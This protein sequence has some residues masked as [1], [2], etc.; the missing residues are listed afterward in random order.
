MDFS[1]GI[2]KADTSGKLISIEGSCSI[3]D[4][5]GNLLFYSN[6]ETVWNKN[7]SEMPNATELIGDQSSAQSSLIVPMPGNNSIYYLFTSVGSGSDKSGLRYNTI[8]MNLNGGLGDLTSKNVL[9]FAPGTEEL[10]GTMHCNAKDYWIIGR[11]IKVDTLKFYA[12]LLNEN[13]LNKPV[14]TEFKVTNPVWNTVGGL[15]FS[16]DGE[17]LAFSSLGSDIYVFN[18]DK[19]TGQ[20]TLKDKIFETLMNMFIQMRFLLTIKNC[21][22]LPG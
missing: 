10:G 1:S 12:Y 16:Q 9:L 6:G 4:T 21:I 15:I 14:I 2:A 3:S 17:L 11:E 13:G 18:F 7:N 5:S 19:E 20:L 8:D 22:L